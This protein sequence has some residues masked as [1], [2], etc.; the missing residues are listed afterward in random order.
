MARIFAQIYR[1]PPVPPNPEPHQVCQTSRRCKTSNILQWKINIKIKSNICV[2]RNCFRDKTRPLLVSYRKS[3][4]LLTNLM[5]RFFLRTKTT[6]IARLSYYYHSEEQKNWCFVEEFLGLSHF[7][8]WL[9]F[10]RAIIAS[11]SRF[12]VYF[13]HSVAMNEM[14]ILNAIILSSFN[15]FLSNLVDLQ[16][17]P[18]WVFPSIHSRINDWKINFI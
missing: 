14:C 17:Y 9:D 3:E 10:I 13:K 15:H 12:I 18:I 7:F 11:N 4:T 16:W 6:S 1:R 5:F 2:K 8:F